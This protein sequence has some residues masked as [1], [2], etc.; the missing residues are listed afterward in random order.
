MYYNVN[1]FLFLQ[2]FSNAFIPCFDYMY[3]FLNIEAKKTSLLLQESLSHTDWVGKFIQ[4]THKTIARGLRL[5]LGALSL[6]LA[7]SR[8]C[9][10]RA[11][12]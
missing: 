10:L 2:K 11:L 7:I 8:H 5:K 12:G 3:L 6:S 4:G 9:E 1:K